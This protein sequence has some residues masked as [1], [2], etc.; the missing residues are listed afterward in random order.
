MDGWW[1]DGRWMDGWMDEW[2]IDGWMG[3]WL[4]EWMGGWWNGGGGRGS[5]IVDSGLPLSLP[6]MWGETEAQRVAEGYIQD[7]K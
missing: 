6:Q 4:G 5:S 2:M 1:M 7:R 3:G